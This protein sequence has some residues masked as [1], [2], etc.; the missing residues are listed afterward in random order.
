MSDVRTLPV[1][2]PSRMPRPSLTRGA[3]VRRARHRQEL[4][5]GNANAWRHGIFATALTHPDVLTEIDLIY[6]ANPHLDPVRDHRLVE[7]LASC[8]VRQ[9][10]AVA[11]IDAEGM[12][13]LLTAYVSR[14]DTLVERRER[15][16]HDRARERALENRAGA[17]AAQ[18][19]RYRGPVEVRR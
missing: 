4:G 1:P 16:V 15:A 9:A 13:D 10:R 8:S 7:Q 11:A 19:A 2:A 17:D 18:L 3:S 6:V 12:T 14:L 5:R